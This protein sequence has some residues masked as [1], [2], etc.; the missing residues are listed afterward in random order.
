MHMHIYAEICKK[1]CTNM[2]KIC[3]CMQIYAFAPYVYLNC[4]YMQKYAKNMHE[5]AK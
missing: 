3:K 1:N 2:Q 4:I 5:H